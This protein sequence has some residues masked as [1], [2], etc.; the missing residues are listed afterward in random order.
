MGS[1]GVYSPGAE[2]V[3]CRACAGSA[4]RASS[5]VLRVRDDTGEQ[6]VRE[7]CPLVTCSKA[8]R[9]RSVN[10]GSRVGQNQRA[11]VGE[12]ACTGRERLLAAQKN[13]AQ[14]ERLAAK[15]SGRELPRV[16]WWRR[17]ESNPASRNANPRKEGSLRSQHL[18]RGCLSSPLDSA[19]LRRHPSSCPHRS[20]ST[21]VEGMTAREAC[22]TMRLSFLPQ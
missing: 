2:A 4:T 8:C 12:G 21:V 9:S 18:S 7:S 6:G 13:G 14:G 15:P 17:R 22:Q 3:A 1:R 19:G 11:G 10:R 16:E 5:E 20:R